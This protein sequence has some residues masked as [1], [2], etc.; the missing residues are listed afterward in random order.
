MQDGEEENRQFIK[1]NFD[2]DEF[3]RRYLSTNLVDTTCVVAHIQNFSHNMKKVRNIISS[4][5]KPFHKRLVQKNDLYVIWEHWISAV[6]WDRKVNTRPL[7]HK[8]TDQHLYPNSSE[9]M[10][11][12]LAED[13]LNED[14]LYLM[15]A[16]QSDLNDGS[17]LNSS[18]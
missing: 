5:H 12:H 7:C 3:D 14:F 15:E 18:I 2:G 4:G 1:S 13:M 6:K 16:F 11:N 10:R 9:K 8:I 17:H